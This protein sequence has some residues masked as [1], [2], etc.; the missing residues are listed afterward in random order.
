MRACPLEVVLFLAVAA[1]AVCS[2]SAD[3][4]DFPQS[5]VT[6]IINPETR[7]LEFGVGKDTVTLTYNTV[8]DTSLLKPFAKSVYCQQVAGFLQSLFSRFPLKLVNKERAT[9]S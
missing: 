9:W 8:L 2:P 4:P 6:A 3:E 1:S 7:L 5:Y